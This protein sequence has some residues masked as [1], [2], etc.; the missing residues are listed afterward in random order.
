MELVRCKQEYFERVYGFYERVVNYLLEN[1]NYPMWSREYPCRESVSTAIL[2]GEQYV[3]L[4]EG[5]IIGAVVLNTDP[6]G[7]YAVGEWTKELEGGEY[8]V[9]HTFAVEPSVRHRGI[10]SDMLDI[11]I[12]FARQE[13]YKA[14]RLDAVPGNIPAINLYKKKNFTYAGTKDLE[15]GFDYIPVFELYELNFE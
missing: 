15:R 8:M 10:G 3:F 12:A 2:K 6:G 9:I 4:E 13:G 11:C 1:I 7:N 14:I 5:N